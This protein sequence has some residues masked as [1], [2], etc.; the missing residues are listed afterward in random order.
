MIDYE[1]LREAHELAEKYAKKTDSVCSTSVTIRF[2]SR[3]E[4]EYQFEFHGVNDYEEIEPCTLDDLITRLQEL[5][6][7]QPKYAYGASLWFHYNDEIINEFVQE[8]DKDSYNQWQYHLGDFYIKEHQLYLSREALIQAQ[9][10]YWTRLANNETSHPT[11]AESSFNKECQHESK[12]NLLFFINSSVGEIPC[13]RCIKCNLPYRADKWLDMCDEQSHCQ[14][15]SDGK[16]YDEVKDLP[17]DV[18]ISLN[19]KLF[20]L[21]K[22]KKCG[23][24]YR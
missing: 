14:H 6:Q 18:T 20:L 2:N 9:I 4:I 8:I 23:E 7:S 1:K 10:D 21:K 24:F 17:G 16:D 22:C 3:H 15:E 11:N 5:T 13:Y 19:P 12:D